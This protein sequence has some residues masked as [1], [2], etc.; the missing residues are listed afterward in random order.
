MKT[1][2][3]EIWEEHE[4]CVAYNQYIDL[5]ET[6]EE[7]QD[8]FIDKQ[9]ENVD[10]P[11]LDKPV[12]NI[13]KKIINLFVAMIV[14]DD[15]GISISSF[16]GKKSDELTKIFKIIE[17]EIDA[18][19]E[20]AKVK[21]KNRRCL[22]NAAIDGDGCYYIH[23]D[24]NEDIG[25]TAKGLIKFDV[26]DNIN[27]EFSNPTNA[28]VQSQRYIIIPIREVLETVKEMAQENGVDESE[29]SQIKSDSDNRSEYYN[30][31]E[32]V[33]LLLKIWKDKT[34]GTVHAIKVTK[35]VVIKKEW[36]TEYKLYPL[37]WLNW[38]EVKNCYH[39]H[40]CI[41]G[42]LPNQMFINKLYALA[43]KFTLEMAFPTTLYDSNRISEWTNEIG[44]IPIQLEDGETLAGAVNR[45]L[46]AHDMS[47]QVMDIINRVF[48]DT[49][50]SLGATDALTGN[51]PAENRGAIVAVQKASGVPLQL[52]EMAFYQFVE[53]YV[54]I[55]I[56][57]MSVDYGIRE[58]TYL[59]KDG[60]EFTESFDFNKLKDLR[61]KLNIDIG[62]SSYFSEI[63]QISTADNLLTKEIITDPIDYLE[64]IPD[65]FVKNKQGLIDKLKQKTQPAAPTDLQIPP[66]EQQTIQ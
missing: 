33:T 3:I 36:D 12:F 44:A 41:S 43:M 6:V 30:A 54:N 65:K 52:Q 23:F 18:V 28:D 49:R 66:I 53:D 37:P 17:T 57:I 55:I 13:F 34:T 59:D 48:Q 14:S 21:T 25:Q 1:T 35:D 42:L 15:I 5:Y 64:R 11:D 32:M 19:I 45:D 56:D 4:K 46:G 26:T 29:I 22:K 39:G 7:N 47:S 8:F 51:L 24:P 2:P 61:L 9:W 50:E 38:E 40:S 63:D 20:N 16:N 31:P 10:A 60:N 62:P 27:V 58:I